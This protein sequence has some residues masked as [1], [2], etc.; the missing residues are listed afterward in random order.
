VLAYPLDRTLTL[1][2][3]EVPG[4]FSKDVVTHVKL[5]KELARCLV[6][7][8]SVKGTGLETLGL[9]RPT[10]IQQDLLK[11]TGLTHLLKMDFVNKCFAKG[12]M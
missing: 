5:Y 10:E 11:R 8:T 2:L 7:R 12:G 6:N 3:H 4:T 9:T 1:K